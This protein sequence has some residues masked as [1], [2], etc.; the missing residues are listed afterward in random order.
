MERGHLRV[1][2]IGTVRA[3]W[4]IGQFQLR[5][6]KS[7]IRTDAKRIIDRAVC[8]ALGPGMANEKGIPNL[9]RNTSLGWTRFRRTAPR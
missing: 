3:M 6:R 4:V 9:R 1:L 2:F 8:R 5:A 7:V